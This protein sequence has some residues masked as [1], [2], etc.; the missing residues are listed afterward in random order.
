MAC[1]YMYYVWSITFPVLHLT[2]PY[3][4][5]VTYMHTHDRAYSELMFAFNLKT[6][7]TKLKNR[8]TLMTTMS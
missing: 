6:V 7:H 3:H 5:I 2:S 8:C 4:I 1:T